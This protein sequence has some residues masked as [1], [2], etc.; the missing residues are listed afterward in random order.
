VALR[1]RLSPDVPLSRCGATVGTGTPTVNQCF[2][3]SPVAYRVRSFSL[4]YGIPV[5]LTGSSRSWST[6][7]VNGYG[8]E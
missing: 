2:C 5:W 8:P 4:A 6:Q 1:P 7:A 3:G